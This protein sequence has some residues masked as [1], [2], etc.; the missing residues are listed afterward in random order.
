MTP[1]ATA[2]ATTG[3][4]PFVG[5]DASATGEVSEVGDGVA[6]APGSCE[7]GI[8]GEAEPSGTVAD[9]VGSDVGLAVVTGGFVEGLGDGLAE[10]ERCVGDGVGLAGGVVGAAPV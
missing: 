9:G 2:M 3:D 6:P 10:G 5:A 4:R 8:V 7:A 1:V